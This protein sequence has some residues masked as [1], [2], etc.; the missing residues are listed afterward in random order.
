M[1]K[2]SSII[3]MFCVL[4]AHARNCTGATAKARTEIGDVAPKWNDLVGTDDKK[5]SLTDLAD[6]RAIVIVA[7]TCNSCPY[8]VDYEDRHDCSAAESMRTQQGRRIKL[9][10]INSN[11]VSRQTAW[12][13]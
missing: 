10:A 11:A 1:L 7:F 2:M 6:A 13:K 4:S 5:H 9:V 3:G 12:K 8:S